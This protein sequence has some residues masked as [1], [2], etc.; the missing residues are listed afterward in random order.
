MDWKK[1]AQNIPHQVQLSKKGTYEVLWTDNFKDHSTIGEMRPDNKQ[2]VIKKDQTPKNTTITYLHEILHAISEEC[3][4]N[5]TESQILKLEKSFYYI[6]KDSNI[7]KGK[8]DK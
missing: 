4:A 8:N 3:Q 5:L 6:L 2:I 1:L 7:F